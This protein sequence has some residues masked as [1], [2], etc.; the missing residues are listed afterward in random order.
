MEVLRSRGV[1]AAILKLPSGASAGQLDVK[2]FKL[3]LRKSPP[4]ETK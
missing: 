1:E 4:A 2:N 3:V